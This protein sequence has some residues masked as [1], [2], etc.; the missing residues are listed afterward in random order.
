[1]VRCGRS[2]IAAGGVAIAFLIVTAPGY[3]E[4]ADVVK[5]SNTTDL[6]L[7]ASWTS[8]TAPTSADVAVWNSTVT[9]ANTVNIGASLNWAGVRVANPTGGVTVRYATGGQS[10]ALG[11]SGIDMSAATQ[12]LTLMTA[13]TANTAG[14]IVIPSSQSWNVA[15]GRT[16]AMFSTS[17]SANQRLSGSGNIAVTGGGVVNLNVGDAGNSTFTAGNGN[18]TYTGNWTI[19]GGSK[20]SSLRNGTHGW[21]QGTITLDNG[22]MSQQQGN[23]SFANAITVTGAGGTIFSDSSG[24]ARYMNLTGAISGTSP[25]SFN[26]VAAM[27]TQEGFILTGSSTFTGPMT[28]APNGTVRIG[29]DA[30]PSLNSTA[31]GTLGS[32]P[33][34]VAITNNGILGF[35]WTN[36]Q[37]VANTITGTGVVRL[38]RAGGVLPTAQVVTL[39]AASTYTGTTQVNAGRL[40]LIGS[41]T[42]PIAVATGANLSGTGSTTG[43]LSLAAGGGLVL[44]GG[45]ATAGLTVNGASFA[46]SN[47]V[48]FLANPVPGM[49]YDVFTYGVG[50]VTNPGN[51]SVGWRGALADDPGSQKYVFTAG[52][53]GTLAWATTSGTWAQ[54]VAGNWTGADGVFYGGDTA[55]FGEPAVS[56]TVTLSGRLAPAAWIVSNTSKSYTF[57]GTANTAEVTGEGSLTKNGPGLL[58]I[59]SAQSYAGPTAVNGGVVDVGNG[60]TTGSLGSGAVSVASGAELIFN[61]SNAFTVANALAGSGTITKKAAG[62]MT[63]SGSN[64]AG[65]LNWNF[66]GIG[67]GDI[68]FANAAALG[69]AGSTI[70]VGASGS[71]SAFFG[72]TG[73]ISDVAISIGESGTFTWNGST[74]NTSTLSGPISGAG[75]FTKVS[76]ETLILAGTSPLSGPVVITAGRMVVNGAL[77]STPALTAAAGATLGGS[78]SVAGTLG[79][80]GLVSPGSSPGILAAGAVDPTANLAFAFEFT[81]TG[82]PTYSSAT[83]SGNDVLRLTGGTP[84]TTPLASGNV[85]DVYLQLPA[86]TVGD[87]FRGG[88]YADAAT[89][90]TSSIGTATFNVWV[91]GNGSGT[92]K[93]FNGQGYYSLAAYD[94]SFTVTATTVADTAAFADGTVNGGVTQWT[95]VPEP[96]MLALGGIGA[97]LGATWLRHRR[98]ARG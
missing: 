69:G 48:T 51:L 86:V 94:P 53:T 12:N 88:F 55:E 81:G 49:T 25:L 62:R 59:T 68:G 71:G 74:G 98:M 45:T 18:D 42:S 91:L 39:S 14:T 9:A 85:V 75:T 61:R 4:A 2:L 21:G 63:V 15:S 23:W 89:D 22:I 73:N 11:T 36:A 56:S 60:G 27:T 66:T 96:G 65:P 78:G 41:L 83:A 34:G 57:S 20:V 97:A 7:G 70:T 29:G 8:G 67:N 76:G 13:V 93:T 5:A 90:F 6:N 35:G 87:V 19:S 58:V 46:G 43:P 47:L 79:G 3:A 52:A 84:F 37:T 30:G 32:I 50:A 82:S 80:G 16:L 17:N 38:G 26:A 95:I 1:M 92:S 72:S 54:G 33:A 44:A 24:N 10:L 28:I 64:S 40:N 31:A 77:P